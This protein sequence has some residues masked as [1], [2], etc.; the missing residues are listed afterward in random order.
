MVDVEPGGAG[1]GV[2]AGEVGAG[3]GGQAV[4]TPGSGPMPAGGSAA[5]ASAADQ[6]TVE[7]PAVK[8]TVPTHQ[9]AGHVRAKRLGF[10]RAKRTDTSAS[11]D[12]RAVEAWFRRRG[13]PL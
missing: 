11:F 13:L 1:S 10:S 8:L 3:S 6:P 4:G 2:G 5:G 12:T 7:I 9:S